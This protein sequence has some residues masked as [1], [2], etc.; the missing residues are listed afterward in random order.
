MTFLIQ[1]LGVFW[2]Y[3]LLRQVVPWEIP[4][5]LKPLLVFGAAFWLVYPDWLT[6]AAIAGAVGVITTIMLYLLEQTS[7][8]F[9]APA[10]RRIPDLPL[11][12]QP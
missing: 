5:V 7:T 11:K 3:T 6:A 12:R 1:T 10:P 8:T 9:N 4:D 2:A